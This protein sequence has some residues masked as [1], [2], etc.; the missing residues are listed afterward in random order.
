MAKILTLDVTS[1]KFADNETDLSFRAM[2][3]G[4]II[5]DSTLSATIKIKQVDVGYLKSVSAKWVDKHIVI[6]SGDLSDLPVGSYLLELWLSSSS[7][8]E[9]YPDSG[10]VKLSI[11][12][13][14]TGIS[15][16][17]ISS[18][19]LGEFQQQFSDLAKEVNNKIDDLHAQTDSNTSNIELKANL[20]DMTS[21]QNAM[22]NLQN[23]VEAFGIT[24]E[25]LV[26]IKSLLDA[27]ASNASE[28]EV[29]ELINSVNV[30]T[31]NISLMSNGDYSPKANQTDLDNLQT[32]VNNQGTDISL[33]NDLLANSV[34]GD[35][36]VQ[37]TAEP[38]PEYKD[39]NA[40]KPNTV[41]NY[42]IGGGKVLNVPTSFASTGSFTVATLSPKNDIKQ[43]SI[44]ILVDRYNMF[45]YRICWGG[46]WTTWAMPDKWSKQNR[47]FTPGTLV[48]PYD[49]LN[50]LPVP[51]TVTYG[52]GDVLNAPAGLS[53]YVI[54]T[55]S[56][57][58]NLSGAMQLL[59]DKKTANTYV[60]VGW[61]PT[62]N[63]YFTSWNQLDK[64]AEAPTP[65]EERYD[66]PSLSMFGNFGVVGD[67]F[68]SGS[69]KVGEEWGGQTDNTTWGAM[70]ARKWGTNMLHL[71][72][73]GLSTR[74]WLAHYD[75]LIKLNASDAQDIYYC[76]LGINDYWSLGLDYIG[77]IADVESGADTFFGNY[78]KIIKAIQTK[79]PKA[80]II[81][82]GIAAPSTVATSFNVAIEALAN[83]FGIP[84]VDQKTDGLF[85]SSYYLNNMV[86]GH[87]TGP[88]YAS[89]ALAFERLIKKAVVDNFTYFKDYGL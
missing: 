67:S 54:T 63:I 29:I 80:K 4:V 22:T 47:I 70:I 57:S 35:K 40:L 36:I 32:T 81:L 72:S 82:F 5:S 34:H 26:T 6:S 7:G 43:Q 73:S 38:A 74:S 60:R 9:I 15:G 77:T 58:G 64:E 11:N 45:F 71:A 59:V 78:G 65:Q 27:I 14:A 61:G 66:S 56:G 21:L 85:T 44:Q 83:H 20:S 51:S 55:M 8:Y 16:N 3:N 75:G 18:I 39:L 1:F 13:N 12:Q 88:M 62:S 24:P 41:V 86:G 30:L 50:T 48:A 68:A 17:L 31:S 42:A 23:E 49:N 28:S 19:T 25:N 53:E 37:N 2:Q 46:N 87:P 76:V 33:V 52:R 10:F 79:A 69:L 89:M 84:Y